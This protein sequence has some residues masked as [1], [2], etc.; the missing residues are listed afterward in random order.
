MSNLLQTTVLPRH[1]Y[2]PNK[3]TVP[4]EW[5]NFRDVNESNARV[6]DVNF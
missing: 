4:L 2:L 1:S 5:Q 6:D 3:S